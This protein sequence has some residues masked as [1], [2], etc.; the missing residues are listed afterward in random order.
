MT[1]PGT[2]AGFTPARPTL[3]MVRAHSFSQR[4][5][6]IVRRN[7]N[8]AQDRL[9]ETEKLYNANP[10]GKLFSSFRVPMAFRVRGAP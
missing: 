5:V 6:S 8:E 4:I 3:L 1:C 7:L 9:E 2:F 10:I